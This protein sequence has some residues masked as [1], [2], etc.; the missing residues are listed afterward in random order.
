MN[1]Q[2]QAAFDHALLA[3]A[4][5]K[6]LDASLNKNQLID[7]LASVGWASCPANRL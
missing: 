7:V 3:R 4:V 6:Q 5:Y 1:I 2:I